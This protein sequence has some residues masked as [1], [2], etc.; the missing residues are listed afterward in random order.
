MYWVLCLVMG[1]VRWHR[2]KYDI[3]DMS[4]LQLPFLWERRVLNKQARK[5]VPLEIVMGSLKERPIQVKRILEKTF[6]A[7]V[8][9]GRLDIPS[10]TQNTLDFTIL[11]NLFSSLALTTSHSVYT[12]LVCFLAVFTHLNTSFMKAGI[13]STL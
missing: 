1:S 10:P 9:K 8:Q 2:G 12:S 11:P 6:F 4:C 13:Y 5:Y 7:V 3:C